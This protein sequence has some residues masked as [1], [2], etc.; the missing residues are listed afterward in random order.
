LTLPHAKVLLTNDAEPTSALRMLAVAPAS[1]HSIAAL[2]EV[3]PLLVESYAT[4]AVSRTRV[5]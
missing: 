1:V 3:N 4:E 5:L 2:R